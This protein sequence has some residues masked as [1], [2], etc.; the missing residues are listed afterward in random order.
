MFP[1]V[2]GHSGYLIVL[3][4]L[5]GQYI[6]LQEPFLPSPLYPP[7]SYM[8]PHMASLGLAQVLHRTLLYFTCCHFTEPNSPVLPCLVYYI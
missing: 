3:F 5:L 8:T 4:K 7:R 1:P 6:V 2:G